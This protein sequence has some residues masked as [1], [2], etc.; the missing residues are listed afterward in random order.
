MNAREIKIDMR[1]AV[2]AILRRIA[3]SRLC[4]RCGDVVEMITAR[5]AA[6]LADATLRSIYRWA[7]ADRVHYAT[8]R[9]GS[10]LICSN[11]LPQNEAVTQEFRIPSLRPVSVS[12]R[13]NS[14]TRLAR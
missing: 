6:N 7:E 5:E 14:D 11:S 12:R 10:L 9:D 8:T 13:S 3:R 1:T 2:Q 4:G